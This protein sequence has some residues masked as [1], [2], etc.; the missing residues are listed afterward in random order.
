MREGWRRE[1]KGGGACGKTFHRRRNLTGG[2][3]G[4][5]GEENKGRK[6]RFAEGK[7]IGRV[8]RGV[9][10]GDGDKVGFHLP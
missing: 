10:E 5:G 7:R 8:L 9:W 6:S 4:R 2:R 1:R 3:R